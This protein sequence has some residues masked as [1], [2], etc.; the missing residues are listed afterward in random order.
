MDEKKNKE[1]DYEGPDITKDAF[2]SDMEDMEEEIAFEALSI[3]EHALSLIQSGFFDDA[4]EIMRQ[5]IGLYEQIDREAEINALKNKIADIY[6]MKEQAFKKE[7]SKEILDMPPESMKDISPKDSVELY[8]NISKLLENAKRLINSNQFDE[9][10]D[11]FD[12]AIVISQ[13]LNDEPKVEEIN[14]YDILIKCIRIY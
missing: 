7:E 9:A 11:N 14:K 12:E 3:V 5:A 2:F 13:Q 8:A 6:I 10:L 1:E 4:I